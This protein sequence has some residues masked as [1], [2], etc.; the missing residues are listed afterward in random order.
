M[1]T[2]AADG[3]VAIEE[4]EARISRIGKRF[5]E[6]YFSR[7]NKHISALLRSKRHLIAEERFPQYL[8]DF[9]GHAADWDATR[10]VL[11]ELGPGHDYAGISGYCWPQ[12]IVPTV[13]NILYGLRSEY[14]GH[15]KNLGRL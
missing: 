4:T 15:L 8:R 10:V 14:R 11:Q 5:D 3:G 13:E 12:G 6:L 7:I 9:L 1:R 2:E